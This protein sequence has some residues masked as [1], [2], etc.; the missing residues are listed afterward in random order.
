MA[1]ACDS[2]GIACYM[3]FAIDRTAALDMEKR[4]GNATRN[5]RPLSERARFSEYESQNHGR[6]DVRIHRLSPR[7]HVINSWNSSSDILGRSGGRTTSQ[8]RPFAGL[9][10]APFRSTH[11]QSCGPPGSG[12]VHFSISFST[13]FF[14]TLTESLGYLLLSPPPHS[15]SSP[16]ASRA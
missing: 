2:L 1:V 9:I 13:S 16:P 15:S 6:I 7:S 12:V 3:S 4:A 11:S 10:L 14:F 8:R 5:Q